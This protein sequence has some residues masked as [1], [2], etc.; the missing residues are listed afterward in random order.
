MLKINKPKRAD[1]FSNDGFSTYKYVTELP[2]YLL[3][4][5]FVI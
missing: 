3:T 1:G 4:G 2:C 5:S